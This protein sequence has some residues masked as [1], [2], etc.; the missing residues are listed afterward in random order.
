MVIHSWMAGSLSHEAQGI[1][2]EVKGAAQ[3]TLCPQWY[4]AQEL[5]RKLVKWHRNKTAAIQ[6]LIRGM[7][8]KTRSVIKVKEWLGGPY[9]TPIYNNE[10]HALHWPSIYYPGTDLQSGT[11]HVLDVMDAAGWT[12]I[13]RYAHTSSGADGVE[14]ATRGSIGSTSEWL[15]WKDVLLGIILLCTITRPQEYSHGQWFHSGVLPKSSLIQNAMLNLQQLVWY[16]LVFSQN[17]CVVLV[18][19][20]TGSFWMTIMVISSL[21]FFS[22]I[23]I[24]HQSEKFP[25]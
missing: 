24:P 14:T 17:H 22:P 12:F 23:P 19:F 15:S 11:G 1:L 6:I 4:A 13:G 16:A 8:D 3:P 20:I 18:F 10:V 2:N 7:R 5:Q 21:H 9:S 25:H